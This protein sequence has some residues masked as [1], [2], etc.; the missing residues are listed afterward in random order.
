LNNHSHRRAFTVLELMLVISVILVLAAILLPS[1]GYARKVAQKAAAKAQL[2]TLQ[3]GLQQ[4]FQDFGFYP[5][6]SPL[7]PGTAQRVY[8]VIKP[9][10]GG[11]MLAEA[12]T[13]YL[14]GDADGAGQFTGANSSYSDA[15]NYG[16]RINRNVSMG[17]KVYG[18]YASTD[19]KQLKVI[20]N[21]DRQYYVD[22]WGKE[23]LYYRS[24]VVAGS[25]LKVTKIFDTAANIASAVAAGTTALFTVDDC[26]RDF[27]DQ[28]NPTPPNLNPTGSTPTSAIYK[29]LGNGPDPASSLNP[30]AITNNVYGTIVGSDSFLLLS[31]GPDGVY[32]TTDDIIAGSK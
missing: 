7:V 10:R 29:A 28:L 32:F 5:P 27:Q 1:L 26:S 20:N 2:G 14:N 12:L 3:Q 11:D 24:N 16:F 19:P 23:I 13:G 22:P 9:G 17:G 4:Y 25:P 15:S 21:G 31:A 30:K 18:P 8:A 6:S